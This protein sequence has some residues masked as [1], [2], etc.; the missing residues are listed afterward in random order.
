MWDVT[1]MGVRG[2]APWS[3]SNFEITGCQISYWKHFRLKMWDFTTKGVRGLA[4]EAEAFLKI[5]SCWDFT[6][7]GVIGFAPWSWSILKSTSCQISWRILKSWSIFKITSH[8]SLP[9]ASFFLPFPSYFKVLGR[10]SRHNIVENLPQHL[11]KYFLP[12]PV[13]LFSSPL[14]LFS[15]PL[16]FFLPF[17]SSFKV[18]GMVFKT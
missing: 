10:V 18:L 5:I 12:F 2:L 3:W 7:I 11:W 17:P 16:P 9:C 6:S 8:H 15:S 14:P 1:S 13:H 4:P